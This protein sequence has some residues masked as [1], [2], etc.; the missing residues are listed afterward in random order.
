MSRVMMKVQRMLQKT[1]VS[2]VKI[3][4]NVLS[5][6]AVSVTRRA[7]LMMRPSSRSITSLSNSNSS[8]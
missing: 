3:M 4:R 5:M 1:A 6:K 8:T 2:S 7:V